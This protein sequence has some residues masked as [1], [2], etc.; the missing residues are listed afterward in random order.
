[1]I[2]F[3]NKLWTCP[4]C[5]QRNHFPP[6]YADNIGPTNLP[7]ELMPNYTTLE[8]DLPSQQPAGPPVFVYLVDT[9][10][11]EEELEQLKDSLQQSLS[12]LPESALLCLITFGTNVQVHELGFAECPKSF[13]FRGTKE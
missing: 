2:D 7:A 10:L 6:H 3:R 5:L 12:L 8:Y 11:E 13:V 4:F 1:M 9:C